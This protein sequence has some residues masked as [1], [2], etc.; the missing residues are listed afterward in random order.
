MTLPWGP[1]HDS[2]W[3]TKPNEENGNLQW[4]YKKK[5]AVLLGVDIAAHRLDFPG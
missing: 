2:S 3:E 5:A 1:A 4:I